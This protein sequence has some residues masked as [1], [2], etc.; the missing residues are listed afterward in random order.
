LGLGLEEDDEGNQDVMDSSGEGR[1]KGR[2]SDGGAD[3]LFLD[4]APPDGRST[5]AN[6]REKVNNNA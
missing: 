3:A 1:T 6:I 4:R 5:I 2:S